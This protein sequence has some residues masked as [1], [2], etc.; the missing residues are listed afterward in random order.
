MLD[1]VRAYLSAERADAIIVPSNDPHFGE[2][3][4]QHFCIRAILSG[5]DG[6]AGT[7]V[8]TL[9]EAALWTDSRYFI[10]AEAQLQGTGIE[11]MKM[12]VEG[13]PT[14]MSWLNARTDDCGTILI[15][16]ALF[17]AAE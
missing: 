6:S 4:Q 5:F 7:L 17:S 14:I 8:I 10:Q 3:V 13:V 11:L 15:D 2:Y 12:G 16:G 9:S 1:R